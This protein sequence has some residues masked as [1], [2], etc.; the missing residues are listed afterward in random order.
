MDRRQKQFEIAVNR[1]M[2][3]CVHFNGIQND[4]CKVGV[5]YHDLVGNEAGCARRLPCT[6]VFKDEPNKAVCP[7]AEHLTREQAEQAVRDADKRCKQTLDAVKAAHADAES[8]NLRQGNGG[9]SSMDCPL[10]CGGTLRYSV[11][12][13][14][15]HMHAKCD[16]KDCVSWME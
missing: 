3:H 8:K 1:E 10:K 5:R 7:K 16:T 4:R 2:G 13:Y 11:A 14:N 9:V 15:G 12:S 6:G